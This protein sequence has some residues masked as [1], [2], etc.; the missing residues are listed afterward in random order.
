MSDLSQ[1]ITE[2]PLNS[3][4]T[5]GT[6]IPLSDPFN[7]LTGKSTLTV[8]RQSINFENAYTSV[9][10]A[11]LKTKENDVFYVFGDQSLA[12]VKGYVNRGNSGYSALLDSNGEQVIRATGMLVGKNA[13]DNMIVES[14]AKLRTIEPLYDGQ[15]II[16]KEYTK[17]SGFGGGKFIGHLE[18][19]V[20]DAGTIASGEGY[21]WERERKDNLTIIDFGGVPSNDDNPIDISDAFNAA[22]KV[23]S[24]VRLPSNGRFYTKTPL[25]L[26]SNT[27]IAGGDNTVLCSFPA[28][29]S[30]G[31]SITSIVIA[32]SVSNISLSNITLD[33]GVREANTVKNYTRPVKMTNVNGITFDKLTIVNNADWSFSIESSQNIRVTNYRQKSYVYSDTS[34]NLNGGRDGSHFMD[35]INVYMDGAVID[36]GD[37]CVGITSKLSGCKNIQ[38]KNITGSSKIASIVIYNEEQQ[39]GVYFSQPC[40]KLDIQ[41]VKVMDGGTAR[42]VVRVY[43]Y[44]ANSVVSN[45]TIKGVTGTSS[46]H[47]AYFGGITGLYLSD[48]NVSSTQQHGI[49]ITN[50]TGVFGDCKGSAQIGT[51]QGVSIYNSSYVNMEVNS[52]NSAGYGCTV[53]GGAYCTI[54]PLIVNCGAG[55]YSTNDGGGVRIVN[56]SNVKIPS[57]IVY[58]DTS[59][60]TYIGVAVNAGQTNIDVDVNSV[61]VQA[62]IPFSGIS[63]AVRQARPI[64]AIHIKEDSAGNLITG[65]GF[66]CTAVK[67]SIGNYTFTITNA[68]KNTYYYPMVCVAHQNSVRNWKQLSAFGTSTLNIGVVDSAGTLTYSD[69]IYVMFYDAP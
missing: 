1:K 66:N 47:A 5:E 61:L 21:H 30:Q 26:L 24:I 23:T 35:C 16:L 36:S 56:S 37:D 63:G 69:H 45:I 51:F 54:V 39:G 44:G 20:D 22:R 29:D 59:K 6:F 40:D 52:E 67:N 34:I 32:D 7:N 41:N 10:N 31:T 53:N 27:G 28:T 18:D 3:A 2:L 49:Y 8:M 68:A 9:A 48:I 25:T 62:V 55:L 19:A 14:F 11:L 58:G 4:P 65:S 33:G 13:L 57:G 50:C 15:T 42:D 38:I 64:A 43:K 17:G 12:Y 60:N 46:N